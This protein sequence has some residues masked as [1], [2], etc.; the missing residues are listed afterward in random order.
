M[1]TFSGVGGEAWENNG[2]GGGGGNLG[3]GG[4]GG[5]DGKIMGSGEI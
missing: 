4:G 5:R 3:G 1:G 2:G